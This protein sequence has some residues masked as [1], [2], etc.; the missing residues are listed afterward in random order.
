[1]YFIEL[2]MNYRMRIMIE[3]SVAVEVSEHVVWSLLVLVVVEV[4]MLLV[5]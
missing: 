2:N 1:M 4:S 5:T 3:C